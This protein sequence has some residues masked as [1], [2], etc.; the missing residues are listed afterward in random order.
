MHGGAAGRME[1]RYFRCH[2]NG[3][4]LG[5]GLHTTEAK[6]SQ[7]GEPERKL[8][9]RMNRFCDDQGVGSESEEIIKELHQHYKILEKNY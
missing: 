3:P 8:G 6:G 7:R 2:G 5:E 4:C 9:H 1:I